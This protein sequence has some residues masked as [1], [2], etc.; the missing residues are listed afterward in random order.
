MD[1]YDTLEYSGVNATTVSVHLRIYLCA[2]KIY[3]QAFWCRCPGNN[4]RKDFDTSLISANLVI[5]SF[6]RITHVLLNC[7]KDRTTDAVV[8]FWRVSTKKEQ[9]LKNLGCLNIQDPSTLEPCYLIGLYKHIY[10]IL[11]MCRLEKKVNVTRIQITS[12][13][14]NTDAALLTN[15]IMWVMVSMIEKGEIVLLMDFKLNE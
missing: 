12:Q 13:V 8:T 15:S 3:Q 7:G 14:T 11:T 4:W 10:I 9:T 5:T 2:F 1:K 6:Y